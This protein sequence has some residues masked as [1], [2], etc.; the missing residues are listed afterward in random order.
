MIDNA[1][2]HLNFHKL[3]KTLFAI[4]RKLEYKFFSARQI[5]RKLQIRIFKK[6][7][8]VMSRCSLV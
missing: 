4:L 3:F 5:L 2:G 8:K 6:K 1:N 7:L